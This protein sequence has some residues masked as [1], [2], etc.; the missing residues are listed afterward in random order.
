[1]RSHYCGEV[2]SK[3]LDSNISIC[4]WVHRRRDH[5]GIIFLDVRDIK[6]ICQVVVNPENKVAFEIADKCR[7]EY[8]IKVSGAVLKRPEGTINENMITGEIELEADKIQLLNKAATPAFPLDDYQEVNE[9][10]R[11]KNRV[12]DLRR[13][14]MNHT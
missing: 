4:G 7:N 11:L 14:E 5:G 6:G 3:D 9:D 8:V 1:M 2:T 10:V 12:L 13:P